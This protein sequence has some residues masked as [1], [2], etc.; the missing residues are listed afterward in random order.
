VNKRTHNDTLKQATEAHNQGRYDEAARRYREIIRRDPRNWQ[1]HYL[2]GLLHIHKHEHVHARNE[3]ERAVQINPHAEEAWIALG[4]I[5]TA[6][7]LAE[8]ALAVYDKM[9]ACNPR[10][11]MACFKAAYLHERAG[12]VDVAEALYRR[13]VE[14][15]PAFPEAWNNFGNACRANG[16]TVDAQRAYAQALA[17]RPDFAEA[18]NNMGVLHLGF[19]PPDQSEALRY[20]EKA[21]ACRD[22]YPEAHVN[23]AATLV[24]L[25]RVDEGLAH[26]EKALQL[27]PD[28]AHAWNNLGAIYYQSGLSTEAAVCFARAV[29]ANPA[30]AEAHNN[31]GLIHSLRENRAEARKSFERA[32]HYRPDFAEAYNGMGL[33][34][35]EEGQFELAEQAFLKAL[36]LKPDFA[37]AAANLAKAYQTEGEVDK[38]RQWFAHSDKLC[39]NDSLRIKLA[40][41]VPAIMGS[42][43]E[44]EQSRALVEQR[45]AEIESHSLAIVETD[46]LKFADTNFFLAFQG[47]NDRDIQASVAKLYLRACPSLGSEAPHVARRRESG[48]KIKLGFISRF[49][50]KHSVGNY[51]APTI[52]ILAHDPRFE[53]T[54]IHVGEKRDEVSASL[55]AAVQREITLGPLSLSTA[56]ERVAQLELDVL[57]YTD[58]GMDPFTYFLSYSRLARLQCVS[59]GH[60]VTTGIPN[61]DVYLSSRYLEQ[62]SAQEHYTE[63]LLQMTHYNATLPQLHEP[64]ITK[65]RSELG[66]PA[67]GAVYMCPS[68]LQKLHPDFDLLIGDLLAHDPTGH[69]VLFDDDRHRNWSSR[70]MQRVEAAI[71]ASARRVLMLPFVRAEDFPQTLCLADVILD[72]YPFGL[73]TTNF[74]ALAAAAPVVT[75]PAPFMRGRG[76][77]ACYRQMDFLDCVANGPAQYRDIAL[78]LAS[79]PGYRA[80]VVAQIRTRRHILFNDTRCATEMGDFFVSAIG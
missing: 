74:M 10:H 16:N 27:K 50:W 28:Y 77:L 4:D 44:V 69:V 80:Q 58:I 78:R 49:F 3:L 71:G 75:W 60:P 48:S 63:K 9:L 1:P 14:A 67:S 40:T 5:Y 59:G 35:T 68:K 43:V 18:H 73:G 7:D 20:F 55:A 23:L 57:V 64:V 2:L 21:I 24:G 47:C 19:E 72:P 56:R 42:R 52:Q 8:R 34:H 54:L 70:I 45:L 26:Y 39:R 36:E 17:L 22:D 25:G 15:K 13:A 76:A 46:L 41:L 51:I 66:L 29:E 53:V 79:D 62:S 33:C 38:A 30:L 61:M 31:E 6:L 65:T 11:G 12:R 37:D 32:L